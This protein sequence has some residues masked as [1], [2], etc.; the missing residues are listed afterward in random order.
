M[1][2]MATNKSIITHIKLQNNVDELQRY[3][4]KLIKKKNFSMYTY[5]ELPV[6]KLD[7][8]IQIY[9]LYTHL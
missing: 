8:S 6:L 7:H 1:N 3:E 5:I 4:S 2:H 9:T